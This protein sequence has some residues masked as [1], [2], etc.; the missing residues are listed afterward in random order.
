MSRDPGFGPYPLLVSKRGAAARRAEAHEKRANLKQVGS[1]AKRNPLPITVREPASRQSASD[2]LPEVPSRTPEQDVVLIYAAAF[3][4]LPKGFKRLLV[5][6]SHLVKPFGIAG[7]SYADLARS[8]DIGRNYAVGDRIGRWTLFAKHQDELITGANDRHLDFRVSVFRDARP[9]IVLSTAV[10]THT[11]PLDAP[12][13][14]RS[15]RSIASAW[16][17]FWAMPRLPAGFEGDRVR[18]D[19]KITP[20]ADVIAGY[21]I[22]QTHPTAALVGQQGMTPSGH[23]LVFRP[24]SPIRRNMQP[25]RGQRPA[26]VRIG[27]KS[28]ANFL[29]G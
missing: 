7:V 17:S 3:G 4:H 18:D 12:I 6:R 13:W 26:A 2:R 23:R 29:V 11:I 5:L 8:I 28:N 21:R 19:S 9:R 27:G 1:Y 10:M 16:Q 22:R 20:A 14:R 15:S 24:P 25:Q